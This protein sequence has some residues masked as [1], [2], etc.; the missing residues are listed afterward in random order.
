MQSR[1]CGTIT[2]NFNNTTTIISNND[3]SIDINSDLDIELELISNNGNITINDLIYDTIFVSNNHKIIKI[4]DGSSKFIVDCSD[5]YIS[6]NNLNK[7]KY[8]DWEYWNQY[9][10]ED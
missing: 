9:Y 3:I 8:N 5:G 7:S 1:V 4:G 2:E 10:K 6:I